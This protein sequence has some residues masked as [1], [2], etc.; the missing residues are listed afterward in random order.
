MRRLTIVGSVYNEADVLPMFF[1]ELTEQLRRMDVQYEIILVNDGST[2]E[3]KDRLAEFAAQHRAVKVVCFSRNFGHEAAMTAGIDHATGD[4]IVCMDT[5]LQHPP[6]EIPRMLEACA[7]GSEIVYMKRL[8]RE[9]AS[10]I[11]RVTSRLFYQALN[12]I[13]KIRIEPDVSDFFLISSRVAGILR[14][15]YKERTRFLRGIIQQVGFPTSVLEYTA[16]SRA[17]GHTKYSFW[18]LLLFSA[19]AIASVSQA[20]LRFS[21]LAA[22][23][24]ML[25]SLALGIYSIIMKLLGSPFSG[26]TTLVVLTSFGFS[27]VLL[28]LGIVGEYLGSVFVESKQRP[29]YIVAEIIDSETLT[30]SARMVVK[31]TGPRP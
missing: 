15:S 21:M 9:D 28:M 17:A 7:S 12:R 2:D 11:R 25:I 26:Y 22:L 20:P 29:V 23:G 10:F 30:D 3:S 6:A 24:F 1:S 31:G 5:D 4:A 18:R 14:T 16:P 19:V 27:V 13:S 8:K